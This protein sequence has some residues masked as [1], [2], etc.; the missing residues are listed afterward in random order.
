MSSLLLTSLDEHKLLCFQT[1][2][3]PD[4]AG[5]C[6]LVRVEEI[7]DTSV[8]VFKQGQLGLIHDSISMSR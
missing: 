8:I 3:T 1:P 4:E 7:G 5:H 2:P 6:D